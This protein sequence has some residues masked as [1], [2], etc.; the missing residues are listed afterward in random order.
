MKNSEIE[1]DLNMWGSLVFQDF[2]PKKPCI[3]LYIL[4]SACIVLMIQCVMDPRAEGSEGFIW[5]KTD[6]KHDQGDFVKEI[7]RDRMYYLV[8]VCGIIYIV[9]GTIYII[10]HT[11]V[12][13]QPINTLTAISAG[14]IFKSLSQISK[15]L[16][17]S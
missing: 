2:L 12:Y 6:L 7:P 15:T 4:Y 5:R 13:K 3:M 10:P 16:Y 8:D 14:T 9:P 11:Y 17:C 1:N